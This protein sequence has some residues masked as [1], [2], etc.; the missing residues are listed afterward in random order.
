MHGCKA[1]LAAINK[2]E[3]TIEFLPD[4]T[5]VTA[6]E[7]FLGAVGYSLDEIQGKH[8]RIF[9]DP[10]EQQLPSYLDFWRKL[11][12]GRSHDGV[13]RRIRKDGS[14]LW[15]QARYFP[16]LNPTG[17]P[18]K[19]VKF[20]RDITGDVILRE[21]AKEAGEAVST[22]IEQL[23]ETISEISGHVNQTAGEATAT[24]AEV[25]STASSVER[26]SDSS[27]EIEKVVE[28]IRNLA[29]QTNLLA[30]NATIESA[31][32]GESGKGFAV[33][34]NEV[35]ELA[36]QTSGATES[37]DELVSTIRELISE[38]VQS[39]SRVADRIRGV[40]ESMTSVASAVEEQSAT[41][42]ALNETASELRLT[43]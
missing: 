20:A 41:M 17:E 30:L 2:A 9:V 13:F 26:L 43:E 29:E 24:E 3:A 22:S 8:H 10:A 35:K 18:V 1:K 31:R 37:I 27:R 25:N 42:Q 36:K 28:V 34:A 4:G 38:S 32:A 21:R 23:V 11:A 6:N 15:I 12:S 7:N 19:V 40:T 33:V 14:D 16:V 39:T 5:I